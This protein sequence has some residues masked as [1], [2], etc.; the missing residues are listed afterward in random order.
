MQSITAPNYQK[1]NNDG[2]M[3]DKHSSQ[4]FIKASFEQ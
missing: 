1:N 2:K 3:N 4:A